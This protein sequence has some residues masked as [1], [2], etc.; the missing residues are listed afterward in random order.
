M[1][2]MRL[3]ARAASENQNS[4]APISLPFQGGESQLALDIKPD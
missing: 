2:Q 1:R 3:A 4:A